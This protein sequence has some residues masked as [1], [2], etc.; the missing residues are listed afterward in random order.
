MTDDVH[1]RLPVPPQIAA[2]WNAL[3]LERRESLARAIVGA[4]LETLLLRPM[5][6]PVLVPYRSLV[7]PE[8]R[9]SVQTTPANAEEHTPMAEQT[10]PTSHEW[11][12]WL[13]GVDATVLLLNL[14]QHIDNHSV[15]RDALVT[16]VHEWRANALQALHADDWKASVDAYLEVSVDAR[17]YL[18]SQRK[19]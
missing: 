17:M 18:L 19:L 4:W 2:A 11:V 10:L 13:S 16:L 3:P 1:I 6:P 14:C 12:R 5:E 7:R 8:E 15:S 9:R